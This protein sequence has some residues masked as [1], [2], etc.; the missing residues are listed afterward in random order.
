[1]LLANLMGAMNKLA[2]GEEDLLTAWVKNLPQVCSARSLPKC[3]AFL[4]ENHNCYCIW[5]HGEN[6]TYISFLS[7][8]TTSCSLHSYIPMFWQAL[9]DSFV[10]T[11][12]QCK[13][14]FKQ[15]GATA[16]V[17]IVTGLKDRGEGADKSGLGGDMLVTVANVG[18]SHAFVDTG[19]VVQRMNE[20]HR[21]DNSKSERERVKAEGGEVRYHG[22]DDNK[23]PLRLWPGGLMM[24]R[25]LGDPDATHSSPIPDVNHLLLPIFGGRLIIASDGEFFFL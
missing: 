14:N 18:D 7:T 5:K 1:M 16:T 11:D 20:D 10:E 4:A 15:S 8:V 9:V 21:L 23:G 6:S 12:R 2:D 17:I 24:S 25:T 13:A 22:E 19:T 3:S